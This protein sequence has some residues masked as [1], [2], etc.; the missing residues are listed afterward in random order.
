VA[1]AGVADPADLSPHHVTRR[2]DATTFKAYDEIYEYLDEGCL[3]DGTRGSPQ[4]RALWAGAHPD[5]F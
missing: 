4:W 5:R 3:L 1:S 2:T